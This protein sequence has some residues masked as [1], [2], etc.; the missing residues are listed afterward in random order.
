MTSRSALPLLIAAAAVGLASSCAPKPVAV[1]APAT[2][3]VQPSATIVLLPDAE[4]KTVGRAFVTNALGTVDLASGMA[5]TRVSPGEAPRAVAVMSEDEV[6]RIFSDVLD[7]LPAAAQHFTLYF[8]FESDELTD[9]S[10]PLVQQVVQAVKNR[11]MPE[12]VVMGHTDTTGT[13]A[14]NRDLGFRR[15]QTVRSMLLQA[16]LDTAFIDVT[17]HGEGEL[18]IKTA[19]E[20]FEP[21]NRRVE[22]TVR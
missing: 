16:G 2:A 17:S 6:K 9:A 10:R 1:Q 7:T 3:P 5:S 12:V 22:I 20:T 19:D 8:R 4:T 14:S 13:P 15:A 18:L 21:R 11:P